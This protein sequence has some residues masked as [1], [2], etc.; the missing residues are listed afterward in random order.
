MTDHASSRTCETGTVH[1]TDQC[2]WGACAI[3]NC[4]A[5][6]LEIT[7]DEPGYIVSF[8]VVIISWDPAAEDAGLPISAASSLLGMDV[9]CEHEAPLQP[10]VQGRGQAQRR[11]RADEGR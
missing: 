4:M 10:L 3:C 8:C 9:V 5:A 11:G 6:L 7:A 1:G 2:Q